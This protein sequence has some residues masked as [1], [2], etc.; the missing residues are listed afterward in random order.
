MYFKI[1]HG[2]LQRPKEL[3]WLQTTPIR[4]IAA[5]GARIREFPPIARDDL[6]PALLAF[7]L[8]SSGPAIPSVCALVGSPG[9]YSYPCYVDWLLLLVSAA[10]T[11]ICFSASILI[12]RHAVAN[13]GWDSTDATLSWASADIRDI[14]RPPAASLRTRTR[15]RRIARG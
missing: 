3:H 1:M 5:M 9:V 12:V 6:K 10:Q 15:K 14:G 13:P 2:T 7:S 11:M 4:A 8:I